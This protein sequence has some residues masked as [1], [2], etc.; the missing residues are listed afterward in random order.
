MH[1]STKGWFM[2]RGLRISCPHDVQTP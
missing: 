2:R 1:V